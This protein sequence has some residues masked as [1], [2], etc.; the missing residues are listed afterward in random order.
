MDTVLDQLA[1]ALFSY[2]LSVL[3]DQDEAVA[4]VRQTRRLAVRHRRRL[5]RPELQRAWLY[6]LNRHVCL[7]RLEARTAPPPAQTAH[8][9]HTA[10]TARSRLAR[11]AWPE[12]AGTTPAQ[13]EALELSARHQLETPEVAAV[14]GLRLD[15]AAVLLAQGTCEVERTAAAL[16]V[17]A[18]D[19]C[20][21]LTRIGRG[22]GPVLGRALRGELVRHVDECPTCRGAAERGAAEG[23]WPGTPR[24]TGALPLVHLPRA[25]LRTPRGEEPLPDPRFD[26]RGFP[27]HLPPQAERAVVVRH[28]TVIGSVA[29]AVVAAPAVALWAMH[30]ADAPGIPAAQ[31]TSVRVSDPQSADPSE[32]PAAPSGSATGPVDSGGGRLGENV[33]FTVTTPGVTTPPGTV[34]IPVGSSGVGAGQLDV[35]AAESGGRTLITLTNTGGSALLWTASVQAPWIRLSRDGGT[36]APGAQ[37]TV[38]VTV[39]EDATPRDPWS[40]QIVFQPSGST[41]TLYGTGSSRRGIPSPT[42][43]PTSASPTPPPTPSSSPTPTPTPTPTP[44]ASASGTPSTAPSGATPPGSPSADP[45]PQSSDTP[46]SGSPVPTDGH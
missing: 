33:A 15:A 3:C 29:A 44:S 26:R 4:A 5:R 37:L 19:V 36:L 46:S 18:A 7:L 45:T 17:L 16:A 1:D 13:R 42:P 40:A 21:E 34:P 2:S 25:A 9:A 30:L 43:S 10:Q 6:A 14:L 35:G 27:V 12:A 39:D 11:L 22:R 20:P 38:L 24:D 28:R 41:V 31:V 23:P 32:G 8:T